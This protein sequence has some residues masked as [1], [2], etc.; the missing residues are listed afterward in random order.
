MGGV[1]VEWRKWLPRPRGEQKNGPIS[2][3][4]QH[5]P[6]DR[7]LTRSQ[8]CSN[9]RIIRGS[10][11]YFAYGSNM[12]T[13][14]LR[15]RCASANALGRATA[16]NHVL[17]FCKRSA[18]GSGKATIV[19]S[20]KDGTRVYGV[21]FNLDIAEREELDKAEGL[22]QGYHRVDDL[23]VQLEIGD[24]VRVSTYIGTRLDRS[25]KPYDWY[26]ALVIAGAQEHELP[27][28]WIAMLEQVACV[29]DPDLKRKNRVDAI[30]VLKEAGFGHLVQQ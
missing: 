5:N 4:P 10:L 26:R 9:Q 23:G 28:E 25:L 13:E 24:E 18:D 20:R 6:A 29:P 22:G 1:C 7:P 21:V 14:R 30:A 15:G 2:A 17:E 16:G 3:L 27:G 12:L 19:Q 8:K 11:K